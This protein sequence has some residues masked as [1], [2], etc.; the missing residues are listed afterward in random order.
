MM[1]S[2]VDGFWLLVM[3]MAFGD[4]GF[5]LLVMVGRLRD[6]LSTHDVCVFVLVGRRRRE[7]PPSKGHLGR[8]A[9]GVRVVYMRCVSKH[10]GNKT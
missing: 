1:A 5:W 9:R 3:V 8:H 2:D 10:L 6:E 7:L 4:D